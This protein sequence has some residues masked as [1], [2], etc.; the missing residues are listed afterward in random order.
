MPLAMRL[1]LNF[2]LYSIHV[3]HLL[4][5]REMHLFKNKHWLLEGLMHIFSQVIKTANSP[6]YAG[7]A[8]IPS[9]DLTQSYNSPLNPTEKRSYSSAISGLQSQTSKAMGT[10]SKSDN[11]NKQY[12]FTADDL[13]DMETEVIKLQ[14]TKDPLQWLKAEALS[15]S[16]INQERTT[17]IIYVA[18][19]EALPRSM[20]MPALI[21]ALTTSCQ[22]NE[23]QEVLLRKN[24]AYLCK[25]GQQ[26]VA[27]RVKTKEDAAIMK[28]QPIKFGTTKFVPWV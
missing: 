21:K 10:K 19:N 5:I 22:T 26:R 24:I 16:F 28:N 2:F 3:I 20:K 15:M 27:L 14:A 9:C 7:V 25:M 1:N 18:E 8:S 6:S 12:K 23:V 13:L 17:T 4:K 11:V